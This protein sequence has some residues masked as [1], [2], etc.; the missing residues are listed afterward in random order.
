MIGAARIYRIREG[1]Q[2]M[3]SPQ[4]YS[5]V[6]FDEVESP[7]EVFDILLQVL[8]D[9]RLTD[10]RGHCRGLHECDPLIKASDLGSQFLVDGMDADARRK[11][12]WM[13]SI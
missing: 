7:S 12:R 1:G 9:G 10:R 4:A 13:Q 3:T 2:L 8:D 6:L 5:V 11:Q